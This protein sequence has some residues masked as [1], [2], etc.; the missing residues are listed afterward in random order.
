M[1]TAAV[2]RRWRGHGERAVAR[3]SKPTLVP[4]VLQREGKHPRGSLHSV[5]RFNPPKPRHARR[6]NM[7]NKGGLV[8]GFMNMRDSCRQPGTISQRLLGLYAPR[9]HYTAAE[10]VVLDVNP[11]PAAAVLPQ[12]P[13]GLYSTSTRHKCYKGLAKLHRFWGIPRRSSSALPKKSSMTIELLTSAAH[14]HSL[15]STRSVLSMHRPR[16]QKTTQVRCNQA[17]ALALH[18]FQPTL[19]GTK[20]VGAGGS[21]G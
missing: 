3:R 2:G 10:H 17:I 18:M 8:A 16:L 13:F 5:A 19:K 7:G 9:T 21:G 6:Q 12:T 14:T 4:C 15:L 1:D 20:R 11:R